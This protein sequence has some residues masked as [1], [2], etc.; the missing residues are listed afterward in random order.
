VL[1]SR[2]QT[3]RPTTPDR[4]ERFLAISMNTRRPSVEARQSSRARSTPSAQALVSVQSSRRK[5]WTATGPLWGRQSCVQP[6]FSRPCFQRPG[7]LV[8]AVRRC[9]SA[10]CA[11]IVRVAYDYEATTPCDPVPELIR[12]GL[13][14]AVPKFAAV[15]DAW[16]V[17]GSMNT[18][19]MFVPFA[20]SVVTAIDP[21]GGLLPS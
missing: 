12:L 17:A 9:P 1:P 20:K 3:E 5:S 2:D 21:G 15:N 16:I 7:L 13:P 11:Q 10:G 19:C 14:E 18:F 4:M 6:V 8:P